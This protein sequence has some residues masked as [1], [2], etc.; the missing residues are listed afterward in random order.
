MCTST[1]THAHTLTCTHR[2][3]HTHTHTHTHTRTHKST[4]INMM[5]TT[6]LISP[7]SAMSSLDSEEMSPVFCLTIAVFTKSGQMAFTLTPS[8]AS[9][10]CTK[11]GGANSWC[12]HYTMI[13]TTHHDCN[14]TMTPMSLAH[15]HEFNTTHDNPWQYQWQ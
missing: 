15:T 12:Y 7:I 5:D 1:H 13:L 10:S 9:T 6:H 14:T 2:C 3:M 11:M 8:L 4:H